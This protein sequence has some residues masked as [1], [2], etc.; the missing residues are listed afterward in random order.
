MI[1]PHTS[2]GAARRAPLANRT[3]FAY[4]VA[5]MPGAFALFPVL[6][7]IPNFYSSEVGIPLALVGT[8]MLATPV[9]MLAICNLFLPPE[10]ATWVHMAVWSAVLTVGT[11]VF[12]ILTMPGAW[13]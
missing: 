8:I 1:K 2:S 6:V 5:D 4:A 7:Y 13:S 12:I 9:L 11:T 10:G 3:L